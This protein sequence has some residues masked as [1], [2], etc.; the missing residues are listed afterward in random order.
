MQQFLGR[1]KGSAKH[2]TEVL[3]SY[4]NKYSWDPIKILREKAKNNFASLRSQGKSEKD[5][6]KMFQDDPFIGI[7]SIAKQ[8]RMIEKA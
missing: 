3:R 1:Y 7:T 2:K 5:I 4:Q 6:I 8:Y